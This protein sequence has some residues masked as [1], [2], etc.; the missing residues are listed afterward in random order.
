ML[1]RAETKPSQLGSLFPDMRYPG[2]LKHLC[3]SEEPHQN[4]Y[5][6]LVKPLRPVKLRTFLNPCHHLGRRDVCMIDNTNLMKFSTL[7]RKK[8][9]KKG[10]TTLS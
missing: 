1:L 8:E 10:R 6:G 4:V 5:A 3:L 9:K 7:W 2:I